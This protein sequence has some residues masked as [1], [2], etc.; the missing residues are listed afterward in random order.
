MCFGVTVMCSLVTNWF[1]MQT[2]CRVGVRMMCVNVPS[3]MVFEVD[4][5]VDALI[6]RL[7]YIHIISYNLNCV[8]IL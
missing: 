4:V 5:N 6:L 3:F 1:G 7:C 8:A 2:D